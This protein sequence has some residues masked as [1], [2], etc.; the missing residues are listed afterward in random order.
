MPHVLNNLK[1]V[2]NNPNIIEWLNIEATEAVFGLYTLKQTIQQRGAGHNWLTQL[3]QLV[4][5]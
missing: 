3:W 4:T 1:T 2:I 5:L